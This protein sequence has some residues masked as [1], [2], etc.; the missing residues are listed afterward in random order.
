MGEGD[1]LPPGVDGSTDGVS[2]EGA[3][4]A[5]SSMD[6]TALDRTVPAR[7]PRQDAGTPPG[8]ETGAT[9]MEATPG[10]LGDSGIVVPFTDDAGMLTTI[11]IL[12]AQGA[13]C[14]SCADSNGCLDPIQQGGTCEVLLDAG[15]LTHYSKTLPDNKPCA[16]I[17]GTEPAN[18]ITVCLQ[19]LSAYSTTL[20]AASKMQTPCLCGSTPTAPC[21][22]GTQTPTG[23]LYDTFACDFNTTDVSMV[24]TDFT[25]PRFG[26]GMANGLLQCA[27]AYGCPCFGQVSG[28][29]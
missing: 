15:A 1:A 19:T 14:L 28:D 18:E 17:L 25:V 5:D 3:R 12:A 20:C 9:S 27:A 11:S 24:Q 26:A 29:P 10:T 8:Q 2:A 4:D 16:A 22:A 13:G 23:V 7:P 21:L 6:A